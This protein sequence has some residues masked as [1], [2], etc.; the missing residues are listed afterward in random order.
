MEHVGAL[1]DALEATKMAAA[2]SHR[3]ARMLGLTL[4]GI[5]EL[6]F[7]RFIE[8]QNY[9]DLM[10]ESIYLNSGRG[11]IN[12]SGV[13]ASQPRPTTRVARSRAS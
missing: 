4:A 5:V 8:A 3:R 11:C 9:L 10:A 12:C 13:W 1:Q 7:G 6:E 2:V